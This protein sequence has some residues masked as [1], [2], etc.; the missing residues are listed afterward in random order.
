MGWTANIFAAE[1]FMDEIASAR[2][3]DP[4]ALRLELLKDFPRGRRV[5]ERVAEMA[6]WNRPRSNGRA[7]GF[8]FVDYSNTPIAGIVEASVDRASGKIQSA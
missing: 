8:A 2:K 1:A 3:T 7:L 4:V 5:V 6:E